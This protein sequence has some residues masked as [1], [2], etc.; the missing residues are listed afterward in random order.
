MSRWEAMVEDNRQL[1]RTRALK[2]GTISFGGPTISCTVRNL[3][4]SGAML[5]VASPLGV[6]KEF[7]LVI[8]S[9]E[10]HHECRIIWIQERRISVSF[11]IDRESWRPVGSGFG[12]DDL[13]S[14]FVI[15][16]MICLTTSGAMAR[17][18]GQAQGQ[19]VP[20]SS[21][22]HD[23]LPPAIRS[24]LESAKRAC[25]DEYITV[26]NGFLRYLQRRPGEEFTAVHFDQI[27]CGNRAKVCTSSGCLHR[28]FVSRAGLQREVWRGTVFEIDM[29]IVS[30]VP[31]IEVHCG[32][33]DHSCYRRLIWNGNRFR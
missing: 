21:G 1:R 4:R 24:T 28:V 11:K 29:S 26:R 31:T 8:S 6:P 5:D 10:A 14:R 17:A 12:E 22:Q 13:M 30:G 20:L 23:R 32:G 33:Y 7:T 19:L 9:D 27:G 16:L 15:A 3:T 2:A 25:G 18:S